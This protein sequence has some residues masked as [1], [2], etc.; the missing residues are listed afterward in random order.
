MDHGQ[1]GCGGS[2]LGQGD[3][4]CQN[5]ILG[6]VAWLSLLH[7]V[8]GTVL[9]SPELC[10]ILGWVTVCRGKHP[11]G[12]TWRGHGLVGAGGA[13]QCATLPALPLVQLPRKLMQHPPKEETR[14]LLEQLF[15]VSARRAAED[16][17]S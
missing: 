17:N 10:C 4:P 13:H 9:G 12:H 11:L 15:G 8:L 2:E 5:Q 7:R 6:A 1:L 14:H 3:T 16:G